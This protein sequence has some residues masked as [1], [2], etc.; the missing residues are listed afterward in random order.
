MIRGMKIK[1]LGMDC[2][3]CA[4]LEG[5]VR[6]ALRELGRADEVEKVVDLAEIMK[7]GVL[8]LP[9]LVVN[10]RVCLSGRV[11]ETREA[12]ELIAG[13]LE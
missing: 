7:Y 13:E 11:P 4:R 12:K 10:E 5:N 8:S 1:I 2:P 6:R 9:A 3:G